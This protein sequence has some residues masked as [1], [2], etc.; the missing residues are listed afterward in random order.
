MANYVKISTIG[1]AP[2]RSDGIDDHQITVEKIIDYWR[3]KVAQVIP[4]RPDLIV[5]PECCDL[6]EGYAPKDGQAYYRVRKDQVRDYFRS[7]AAENKCYIAYSAVREMPDGSWRNSTTIIDRNG[8]IAGIY[9]KNHAMIEETTQA[10]ILCGK[11]APMIECDFGRVAC[12]ICF[13]LNF[14]ELRDRYA[15]GKPDLIIFCS[16]Y[17]G[18]L[19]QAWWAYACRA[20]FVA[21][22]AGKPSQIRNPQGDVLASSTNYHDFVTACINLDCQLAH[23]DGNRQRLVQL[24]KKYGLRVTIH[25]PG[26]LGSVLVSSED[27]HLS[28]KEMID[29]FEIEL[30]DYYM[31][32]ALVHR[33]G[34]GN[35]EC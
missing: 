11:D 1:A 16:A 13:D 10:G 25:D 18:G 20:H 34:P 19:A 14:Q 26:Y 31:A 12:V 33:H 27:G 30:L 24:K 22:I 9:N 35:M 17:H 32:R 4:D 29:E 8:S 5:V 7:V 28:A 3:M 6:P 2:F 23:L 21:A 15:A